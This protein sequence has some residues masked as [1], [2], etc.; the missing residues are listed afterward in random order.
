MQAFDVAETS[1]HLSWPPSPPACCSPDP[2]QLVSV[3]AGES[4]RVQLLHC[5]HLCSP[6]Q[7]DFGL[8]MPVASNISYCLDSAP[9]PTPPSFACCHHGIA[10]F[11][12][13][14]MR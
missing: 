10:S 3:M 13:W 4:G 7:I 12:M 6:W 8:A 2:I 14:N 9:P 11:R 5:L 1:L